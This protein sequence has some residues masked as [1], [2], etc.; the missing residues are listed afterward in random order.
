ME[1]KAI[2]IRWCSYLEFREVKEVIEVKAI[3]IRWCFYLEVREVKEVME[4]NYYQR[5]YWL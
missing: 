5:W 1:V 2:C 3:C 4:V